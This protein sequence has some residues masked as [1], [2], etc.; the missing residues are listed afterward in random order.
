M[1]LRRTA[2]RGSD[3]ADCTCTT[4]RRLE[5]GLR[6]RLGAAEHDVLRTSLRW[7]DASTP[8]GEESSRKSL[9]TAIDEYRRARRAYEDAYDRTHGKAVR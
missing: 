9:R 1:T 2:G 8:E 5:P 7:A 6:T 4:W 3:V